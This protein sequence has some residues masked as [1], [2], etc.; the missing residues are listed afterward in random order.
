LHNAFA[1]RGVIQALDGSGN[2]D[3]Y[4]S[5]QLPLIATAVAAIV[6]LIIADVVLIRPVLRVASRGA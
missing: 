4:A 5:L 1:M 2:L 6:V 3:R